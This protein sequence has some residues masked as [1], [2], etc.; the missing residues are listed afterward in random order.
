MDRPCAPLE[1]FAAFLF[2]EKLLPC[3]AMDD[4]VLTSAALL[5]Y[6]MDS[7]SSSGEQKGGIVKNFLQI[8]A[9]DF[10]TRSQPKRKRSILRRNT[11]GSCL[12]LL[13][14]IMKSIRIRHKQ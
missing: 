12:Q 4:V 9:L 10:M 1:T 2:G 3:I 13:R 11:K 8:I 5:R 14:K 6:V 7:I